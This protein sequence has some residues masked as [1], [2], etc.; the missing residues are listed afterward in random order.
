[1]EG[2]RSGPTTTYRWWL[3]LQVGLLL[4]GGATWVVGAALEESF[5]TGAGAG[6]LVGALVLR[7]GRRAA[8]DSPHREGDGNPHRRQEEP[9]GERGAAAGADAGGAP[10]VPHGNRGEGVA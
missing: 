9:P 10:D 1:M 5:L 8:A 4:A 6:M 2:K 7:L 3:R